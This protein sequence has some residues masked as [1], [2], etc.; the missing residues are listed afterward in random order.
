M[1]KQISR[2]L[3]SRRGGSMLLAMLFML[4][5]VFIGG[6]VLTAATAN[7]YRV[8]H[9]S[10]QQQYLDQRSAALLV[11]DQLESSDGLL[12][13]IVADAVLTKQEMEYGDGGVLIPKPGAAPVTSHSVSMEVRSENELTAMQRLLIE[14]AIWRYLKN[15]DPNITTVNVMN[16]PA[17]SSGS[18]WTKYS[19]TELAGETPIGGT[20][21][22]SGSTGGTEFANYE[23][24][25]ACNSD[26]DFTV[27]F[28]A[29]SQMYVN[30][31]AVS[32][33]SSTI[34][35]SEPSPEDGKIYM[36]TSTQYRTV[37]AWKDISIEKGA[38]A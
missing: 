38:D 36:V 6:T 31:E 13:L 17:S 18:F 7:G 1:L 12:Q 25:Y 27:S 34:S 22:V 37:I 2:K 3:R 29:E 24:Y 19:S 8:A 14:S 20:I 23:A 30:A 9:L 35:A 11:S 26:F 10:D 28:G 5:C 4:F 32:Y 33:Q 21:Q 16:F 15:T